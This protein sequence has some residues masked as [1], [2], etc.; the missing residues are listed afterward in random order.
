MWLNIKQ[1]EQPAVDKTFRAKGIVD[2]RARVLRV[3]KE[4]KKVIP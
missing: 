2:Y 4:F 1:Y 3:N